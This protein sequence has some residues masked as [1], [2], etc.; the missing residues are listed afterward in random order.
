MDRTQLP[1]FPRRVSLPIWQSSTNANR[2]NWGLGSH[3][4]LELDI[5]EE[6]SQEEP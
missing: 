4:E 5:Q 3:E 2:T 6:A 1:P